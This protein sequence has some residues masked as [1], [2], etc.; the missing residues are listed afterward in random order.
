MTISRRTAL[1]AGWTAAFAAAGFPLPAHAAEPTPLEKASIQ[2]VNDFCASPAARDAVKLASF[3]GENARARINASNPVLAPLVGRAGVEAF[4]SNFFKQSTVEFETLD[5]L[6]KGPVVMN[7]RVDRVR[8]S[9]KPD[10]DI[11]L[12]GVFYVVD[13]KIQDWSDFV[14]PRL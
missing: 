1:T 4:F 12:V 3:F 14:I 8:T 6:A 10:R 2:V 11:Y 7:Y 5:T 9:G 13:G